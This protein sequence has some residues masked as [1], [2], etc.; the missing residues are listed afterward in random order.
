PHSLRAIVHTCLEPDK[1]RRTVPFDAIAERL[2]DLL[3]ELEASP[4]RL[5]AQQSMLSTHDPDATHAL[6][7]VRPSDRPPPQDP[8]LVHGGT[9]SPSYASISMT[10]QHKLSPRSV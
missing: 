5:P 1:N 10:Q 9:P 2:Y 7:V 6:P 4:F 8:G 3:P